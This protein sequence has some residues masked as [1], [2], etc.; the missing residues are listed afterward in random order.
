M[1]NIHN[2]NAQDVTHLDVQSLNILFFDN[3]NF[4]NVAI[5]SA[6]TTMYSTLKYY[7]MIEWVGDMSKTKHGLVVQ[8]AYD[9]GSIFSLEVLDL[10]EGDIAVKF[11]NLVANS[12][13]LAVAHSYPA[14]TAVLSIFIN[15]YK[16]VLT[17]AVVTEYTFKQ[18]SK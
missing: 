8:S 13:F 9:N 4:I 3:F 5:L 10:T 2:T 14:I 6:G 15:A 12:A 17:L 16:N 1:A 18:A 11:A 7:G